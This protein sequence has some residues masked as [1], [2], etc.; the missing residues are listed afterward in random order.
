M[1]GIA[2]DD[3]KKD[4]LGWDDLDNKTI[5][6][7]ITFIEAKEMARDALL[8]ALGNCKHIIVQGWNKEK[9]RCCQ[10]SL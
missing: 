2:D 6:Q 3:V 7:T 10:D 1:A 8:T 4:V 9:T 5:D